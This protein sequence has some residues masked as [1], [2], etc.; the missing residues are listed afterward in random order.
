MKRYVRLS[1]IILA[2]L[3]GYTVHAQTVVS[4]KASLYVNNK[5]QAKPETNNVSASSDKTPPTIAIT[6][7]DL[8]EGSVFQIEDPEFIL[9]GKVED[10]SG[11]SYAAV[12]GQLVEVTD[13]GAFMDEFNLSEG[14]NEIKII[15]VDKENNLK[16]ASYE[17]EYHKPVKTLAEKILEESKYYALIIGINDYNDPK[18]PDLDFPVDDA[19]KIKNVLTTYYTFDEENVILL[20]NATYTEMFT[21]FSELQEKLTDKDNLLI[22]YAGHGDYQEEAEL[23]YW[24]PSDASASNKGFWLSNTQLVDQ[25]NLIK[26]HHTLLLSDACFSGSIFKMRSAFQ[27]ADKS[28][29]I[30]YELKS[31]KAMTSGTIKEVPDKSAFVKYLVSNL[32]NNQEQYYTSGQLFNSINRVVTNMTEIPPQWGVIGK[33]E[34]NGGDFIF[35]RRPEKL[36]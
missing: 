4:E 25:L 33:T 3:Y 23:G 16:R 17:V 22:F 6:S 8:K 30:M 19:R 2:A 28:A 13:D 20:E 29:E 7:H 10:E 31:R 11:V 27:D 5:Q 35:I 34:D 9:F 26:S 24:L 18:I 15:A 36:K 1:L 12:N 32:E 14:I 21:V